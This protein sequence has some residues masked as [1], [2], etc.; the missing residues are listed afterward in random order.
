MSFSMNLTFVEL[1]NALN[2]TPNKFVNAQNFTSLVFFL[3][4]SHLNLN[5]AQKIRP[6]F[7]DRLGLQ[8]FLNTNFNENPKI[9]SQWTCFS[10]SWSQIFAGF[11]G[12]FV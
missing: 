6:K 1:E 8:T 9:L 3:S 4:F 12:V 2:L 10:G 5:F 7:F 11:Q